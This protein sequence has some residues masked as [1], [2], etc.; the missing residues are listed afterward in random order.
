MGMVPRKYIL[1]K[2]FE[3]FSF[4]FH[5]QRPLLTSRYRRHAISITVSSLEE[6]NQPHAAPCHLSIMFTSTKVK[7]VFSFH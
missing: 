1:I 3:Y 2:G 6:L 5:V 4:N 7:E